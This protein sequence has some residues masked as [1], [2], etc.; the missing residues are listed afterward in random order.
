MGRRL[1]THV[2]VVTSD[3]RK[4]EINRTRLTVGGD[5]LEYNKQTSTKQLD[6]KLSKYTSIVQYQ[7]KMQK[8]Q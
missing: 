5:R 1:R 4:K 7:Q 3:Y 8:M 6:S 2:F